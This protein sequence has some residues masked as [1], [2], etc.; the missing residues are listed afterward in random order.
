[1]Q[2]GCTVLED[3]RA[4]PYESCHATGDIMTVQDK[5]APAQRGAAARDRAR[6]ERLAAALRQNLSRRKAQTRARETP[7]PASQPASLVPERE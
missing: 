3:C 2:R 5:T 6:Q 4:I 1:M 7:D